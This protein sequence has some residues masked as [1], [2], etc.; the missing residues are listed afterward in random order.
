VELL[1][2]GDIGVTRS[3]VPGF[4][5]C[6]PAGGG[7]TAQ[8]GESASVATADALYELGVR[9]D[10]LTDMERVR[11]DEAGFLLDQR[12]YIRR[13]TYERLS[14]AARWILDVEGAF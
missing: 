5:A 3:S 8:R 10:T 2:T 12:R 1:S 9:N 4:A 6:W 13:E 14:P 11:L 7:W